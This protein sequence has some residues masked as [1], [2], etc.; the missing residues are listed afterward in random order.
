MAP[1]ADTSMEM[2]E[3][4][5]RMNVL[6]TFLCAREA[7]AA[8]G[9]C[10]GRIVHVAAR[11]ALIPTPGMVAY[12][13]SKAAVVSMTQSLAMEV[14]PRGI[15]INAVVPSIMDTPANRAAMPDADHGAWPSTD[16]VARTIA[17]LASPQN[18][19]THGA[20]VPTYG[21]S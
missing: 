19:V 15:W 8:M 12:S 17:F 2:F 6:S 10:G 20:I 21:R 3:A 18:T 9:E 7:I 11:P 16:D 4:Q 5:Y 13:A 14:A 1:I